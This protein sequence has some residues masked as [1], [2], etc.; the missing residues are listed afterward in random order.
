M[1]A[2][3]KHLDRIRT[4]WESL[5][6]VIYHLHMQLSEKGSSNL[7]SNLLSWMRVFERS[8]LIQE[9]GIGKENY[10]ASEVSMNRMTSTFEVL[11][12]RTAK[13]VG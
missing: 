13:Y 6:S 1:I 4:L 10:S 7:R 9:A 2:Q 8:T 11:D 3:S 12:G 5:S